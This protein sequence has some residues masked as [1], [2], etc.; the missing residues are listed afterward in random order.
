MSGSTYISH[1]LPEKSRWLNS[2]TPHQKARIRELVTSMY[3]SDPSHPKNLLVPVTR[4][5]IHT[6]A[7]ASDYIPEAEAIFSRYVQAETQKLFEA[8]KSAMQHGEL[9]TSFSR[10]DMIN[11][12]D[13]ER[14]RL[15]STAVYRKKRSGDPGSMTNKAKA[16]RDRIKKRVDRMQEVRER[17]ARLR[18]EVLAEITEFDKLDE[19]DSFTS[20]DI[21]EDTPDDTEL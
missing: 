15:L 2:L 13:A 7:V 4:D 3:D 21:P 6:L 20:D 5:D 10:L 12:E 17:E 8:H 1:P 19:Y 9:S 14:R 11:H 16:A 18:E